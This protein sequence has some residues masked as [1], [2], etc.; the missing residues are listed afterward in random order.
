MTWSSF[1]SD[2]KYLVSTSAFSAIFGAIMGYVTITGAG[3]QDGFASHWPF[4]VQLLVCLLIYEAINYT[5]HRVMHEGPGKF[6][7]FLWKVHAAHHLPP[8]VYVMMH[9]VFHPLNVLT[10]TVLV[11]TL[12]I[13]IVGYDPHV[14]T[15]FVLINCLNG[16]ISHFNVDVRM[17][18]LNY[19]M[20][21][22]E[23]HR[24]HHSADIAEAKNYGSNVP[25]F[26]MLLGTFVYR[27]GVPP[28]NLG[29]AP[30]AGYPDYGN[31]A[32]VLA[33]PFSKD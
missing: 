10:N 15:M 33:L 11:M 32:K 5:I 2:L 21:G 25:W 23:I 7:Q 8:K 31:Y 4:M 27:P 1:L 30:E 14:V 16:L 20:V 26:D 13:W 6:G 22:T 24:Y 3:S 9:A 19:I 18:W 28:K 17:G 29:V 12:P